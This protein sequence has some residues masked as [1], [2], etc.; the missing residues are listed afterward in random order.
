MNY[1]P[2]L[3]ILCPSPDPVMLFSA[4]I[5]FAMFAAAP[6]IVIGFI[7][8]VAKLMAEISIQRD[9]GE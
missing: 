7:V 9:G 1:D 5:Q 8:A 2:H 4:L 3:A 6:V